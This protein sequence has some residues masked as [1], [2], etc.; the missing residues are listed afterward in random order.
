MRSFVILLILWGFG[1]M[2][3]T[4]YTAIPDPNFEAALSAYDD[5]PNDH[6]IPTQAIDT[7]RVLEIVNKNI[8]DLTGI[9]DFA[10][11][12]DLRCGSNQLTQLDVSQNTQLKVLSCYN[13]QMTSLDVSQNV[14]LTHL[15]VFN[16]QLTSIDVSNNPDLIYL[17]TGDNPIGYLD[18][19][20]NQALTYLYAY[21]NQLN[22]IDISHNT[23]L[24][25]I[26]LA[27]NNI[28]QLDVSNNLR[29]MEL[30]VRNNQLTRIDVS[31]LPDLA[32]L[33]VSNNQLT[34]LNLDN[35]HALTKLRFND[36]LLTQVSILNGNTQ[37][38]I[39]GEFWAQN[40]PDLHCIFV[41]DPT[42]ASQNLTHID[43][44]THFVATQSECDAVGIPEK[45]LTK[46]TIYPNP[47]HGLLMLHT[48]QPDI[49]YEVYDITG[50]K[51]T[52]GKSNHWLNIEH[53]QSGVYLVKPKNSAEQIIKFVKY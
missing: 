16:N 13:N 30:N 25:R 40:N 8:A 32:W 44:Q 49:F 51:I 10:A 52:Q 4:Q 12:Q 6:Q 42:W 2:A 22:G 5:I 1:T 39:P 50:K 28:R 7:I 41:N 17:S 53:L 35:N 3:Q 37:N 19:T 15:Q 9:Q 26:T 38:L 14:L 31:M 20:N 43:S 34:D 27:N 47:T 23:Q 18:V 45:K 36:N 33:N 21:R 11:L 48:A 29:L 46:L 24:Y